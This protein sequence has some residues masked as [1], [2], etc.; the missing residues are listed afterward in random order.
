MN[1]LDILMLM[2]VQKRVNIAGLTAV[3]WLVSGNLDFEFPPFQELV[4]MIYYT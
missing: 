1:N 2:G 3:L 4:R